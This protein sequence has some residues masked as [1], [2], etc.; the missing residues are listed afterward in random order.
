[1]SVRQVS[2]CTAAPGPRPSTHFTHFRHFV[3]IKFIT[4]VIQ[5]QTFQPAPGMRRCVCICAA[6]SIPG[7]SKSQTS[8]GSSSPPAASRQPP[9]SWLQA[10][11][12]L[13]EIYAKDEGHP[14]KPLSSKMVMVLRE[15][16]LGAGI[17]V[18]PGSIAQL[19]KVSD[20]ISNFAKVIKIVLMAATDAPDFC[21]LLERKPPSESRKLSLNKHAPGRGRPIFKPPLELG[22][23]KATLLGLIPK[24]SFNSGQVLPKLAFPGTMRRKFNLKMC[25]KTSCVMK[26][27]WANTFRLNPVK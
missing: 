27:F 25:S 19:N 13:N 7:A 21:F 2:L 16:Q 26:A 3:L 10:R 12:G 20:V 23:G 22:S 15:L 9:G 4:N 1:M 24:F 8:G 5:R 17:Y 6:L 11:G 18:P 14:R